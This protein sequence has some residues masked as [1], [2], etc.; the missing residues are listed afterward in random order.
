M[1][2]LQRCL[3][4]SIQIWNYIL[5]YSFHF[6]FHLNRFKLNGIKCFMDLFQYQEP[7]WSFNW[8]ICNFNVREEN[9]E[10]KMLSIWIRIIIRQ[11]NWN[12][13]FCAGWIMMNE[14]LII[15]NQSEQH[16][17]ISFHSFR[18]LFIYRFRNHFSNVS[19]ANLWDA[20]KYQLESLLQKRFKNENKMRLFIYFL[21]CHN[22]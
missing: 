7:N 20:S 2:C 18:I 22:E 4:F 12:A 19:N 16:Q 1:L 5:S 13:I 11:I 10:E 3:I 8:K 17:H 6:K 21:W 9:I 15:K 14:S